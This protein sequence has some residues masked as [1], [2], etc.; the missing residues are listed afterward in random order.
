MQYPIYMHDNVIPS[1]DDF[2][3]L[4]NA[5][6]TGRQI[7]A[8]DWSTHPL[9]PITQWPPALRTALSMVLSCGFP[10]YVAWSSD[11]YVLYNEAY[12]SV[13]GKRAE[14]DQGLTLAA[15]WPEIADTALTIGA[16]AF[17]GESIFREDMPFFIE[18]NG[19]ADTGYFTFSYSAIRDQAGVIC[20]VLG[21]VF[22]TTDKVL[23]LAR[24]QE[25]E[26]RY[27]LSLEAG[28]MGTWSVDPD[29]GVTSM[30]E[31]FARLFGVPAE[32]AQQGASL[33]HFTRIIHPD[34]R[35]NVLA[36]VSQAMQDD[37]GYDIDYRTL[38]EAGKT[39]WVSAKGKMF[40]EA[41][42]GRRR[43]AGVATEIT[44]R[45]HI[46]LTLQEE[47]KRKDEFLAMLAH[48]LRNPLAPISAAAA[49]L[50]MRTLDPGRVVT[51]SE[52]I[53]R[54]VD[55]M[56]NLIDD[57][58]DV[59]RVTRG[60]IQ[61]EMAPQDVGSIITDS[62]EQAAP[63]MR[64]KRQHIT[65]ALPPLQARIHA[66]RKRLV[67]VL[68][69]ILNNAVKYTPEEG[70]IT[71]T[72]TVTHTEVRIDVIDDGIGMDP[73]FAARAFDLFAQAERSV[74]RASGGLGLGLALV[75]SLTELHHGTVQAYSAGI[76]TGSTF[77]LVLPRLA[78]DVTGTSASLP[79]APHPGAALRIMVVDDNQDAALM[80]SM[81]LGAV[82]H[83]VTVQYGSTPALAAAA[84]APPEVFLLD[85]GLPE[86][87]GNELARRL[88]ALPQTAGAVLIAVT[89][90]G[91][92]QD[93]AATRA[94]G[95]DHHLVKPVDTEQ[96]MALL[97]S[98]ATAR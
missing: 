11:L 52:I 35:A 73:G 6:A 17:A 20:G 92:E 40:I 56:T 10:S 93:R 67:Q 28:Q 41:K 87:D 75:K 55:H 45:K 15:L 49:L 98:I 50:R 30:D 79:V 60:L 71:L 86:M 95:F 8:F 48:E 26:A 3:F 12:R 19:R 23:A 18:R 2:A 37:V 4:A 64:A 69:N 36:A 29:T 24:H 76:G 13:L 58:L 62:V 54:Q 9:G 16:R 59:S 89:G 66:D 70:R 42:T 14:V 90:Y 80:L 38:P 7:A 77:S 21:V 25:T 68:A 47:G 22:E 44:E 84:L 27:Q 85:I 72:I 82:G 33:E 94:A 97:A 65:L 91:Q 43:F 51:T 57:L 74:D 61:L 53:G 5:G 39:V 88:R 46:E 78:D 63:V 31:R 34:D 81:L 1:P 96:L 32:V 83:E